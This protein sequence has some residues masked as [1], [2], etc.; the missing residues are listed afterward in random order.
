LPGASADEIRRAYEDKVRQ[1]GPD[2]LAG[3]P[4]VVV[5][6]AVRAVRLLDDAWRVLGAPGDRER[7]DVLAGIRRPGQGLQAPRSEPSE[8]GWDLPGYPGGDSHVA[9]VLGGL[10][11]LADGLG[12]HPGP[13][14]H[15]VVP[16]VCNLFFSCCLDVAARAGLR[17]S[18]V[19]LTGHPLPVDGLVVGQS[20]Q[21][22]SKVRRSSALTVRVWHPARPSS[23]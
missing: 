3:A 6:A 5:T 16:D 22:G 8:P 23:S 1:L 18:A 4:L 15:V 2:R 13:P 19:R 10:A 7:Y 20:P 9:A 12:P 21:P 11:A 14:R 17:V